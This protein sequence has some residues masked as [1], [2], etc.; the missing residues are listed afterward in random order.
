MADPRRGKR[1][2][3]RMGRSLCCSKSPR[4]RFPLLSP[5]ISS[6]S[7]LC[8]CLQRRNHQSGREEPPATIL[9]TY[10][11]RR[12][13]ASRTRRRPAL[14]T[15]PH[16]AARPRP[17][18]RRDP[19]SRPINARSD[20]ADPPRART[21]GPPSVPRPGDARPRDARTAAPGPRV[22]A[23]AGRRPSARPRGPSAAPADVPPPATRLCAPAPW[24]ASAHARAGHTW[25]AGPAAARCVHAWSAGPPSPRRV[26]PRTSWAPA[27]GRIPAW[28][29]E[30]AAAWCVPSWRGLSGPWAWRPASAGAGPTATPVLATRR[31]ELSRRRPDPIL[32]SVYNSCTLAFPSRPSLTPLHVTSFVIP[33]VYLLATARFVGLPPFSV[34]S[35]IVVP[36][37]SLLCILD[38]PC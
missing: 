13:T 30:P 5:Q 12:R 24:C 28:S 35:L 11:Q 4:V 17:P 31:A 36:Y 15:E 8:S 27:P 25:A 6:S 3:C 29:A 34:L 33:Y 26:S 32:R 20:R 37:F 22:P 14:R 9:R 38:C 18:P 2:L 1:R 16:I 23:S 19:R 7:D 21:A 10:A